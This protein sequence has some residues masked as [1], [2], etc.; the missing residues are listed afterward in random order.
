[1]SNDRTPDW[2]GMEA[3][4]VAQMTAAVRRVRAEYPDERVYGAMFH[5]FYGDG[6]V[7][8]WP[9]VTVGTEELLARALAEAE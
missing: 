9:C 7:I 2:Q 1:M 4:A 5:A 6:E 3:A 8:Y